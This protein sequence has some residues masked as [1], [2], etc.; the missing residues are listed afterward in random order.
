MELQPASFVLGGIC[1]AAAAVVV[2]RLL[3]PGADSNKSVQAPGAKPASVTAPVA[4]QSDSS[5]AEPIT[6]GRTG[7][8]LSADFLLDQPELEP[9]DTMIIVAYQLPITVS[10]AASGG[11]TVEWDHERGLNKAGMN[12][13]TRL[14]YV[15][16]ISLAISPDEGEHGLAAH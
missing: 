5:L 7:R 1:S 9:S 6:P 12:L 16:C 14:I 4:A 15:G 10:R 3:G 8:R 11:F 2:H 13:P